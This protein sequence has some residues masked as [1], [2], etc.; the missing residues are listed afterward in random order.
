MCEPP[1]SPEALRRHYEVE[2]ELA[3]RLRHSS[4]AERAALYQT[5]YTELFARVPDHPR[6]TR[7]EDPERTRR[8][9]AARLALLRPFLGRT[10][11][12]LEIAPG[13]CALAFAMCQHARE[14]IA[15]DISDQTAPTAQR[16]P[17]FRLVVYDGYHLDLPPAS[18]DLAFS[19]QFLEHL[20]PEDVPG[21]LQLIH[22]LLRPGGVYVLA[23]PHRFSGP[24][25]ISAHF[26]DT[27][28]GFHLQEWTYGEL[29]TALRQHGF[30]RVCPYRA[31]RLH[32][33]PLWDTLERTL[34][35]I[36]ACFPRR[37]QRRL[38]RRLFQ[39]VTVA[40]WK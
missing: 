17:N 16:P 27:P 37:W 2:R 13:D 35:G 40:A 36:W 22:R 10:Q 39:S 12:F 1:R 33:H 20:H 3:R 8:A 11:T 6:L 32:A 15:V 38:S 34:E 18:V 29:R 30:S 31:G 14:V 25:D 19:Y 9:V 7:R 5:L 26:S 28:E 4:R 21:H 24:H 23:T